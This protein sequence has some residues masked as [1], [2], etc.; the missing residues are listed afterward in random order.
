MSRRPLLIALLALVAVALLVPIVVVVLPGSGGDRSIVDRGAPESAGAAPAE[1]LRLDQ[2]AWVHAVPLFAGPAETYALQAGSLDVPVPVVDLEVPF[3]VD[4]N[5]NPGRSPAVSGVVDGH[6]VYV[7]DDGRRSSVR[8]V[9]IDANGADEEVATLD[10]I[11][12]SVAVAPDASHAYLALGDRVD[13][14]RDGG[15][16]RLSLDGLGR[17]ERILGPAPQAASQPSIIQAAVVSFHV[18]IS[19]SLDGRHLTRYSCNGA[20]GCVWQV[21]D[22]D[23]L[24]VIE[25]G[26]DRT[27]I[28]V[29]GGIAL[30]QHCRMECMIELVDLDTGLTEPIPAIEFEAT[31]TLL[32]GEPQVVFTQRHGD[33]TVLRLLDPGDGSVVDVL[34]PR[35]GSSITLLPPHAQVRLATPSGY[36]IAQISEEDHGVVVNVHTVAVR[37]DGG[38]VVELP[39]A[40][41]RDEFAGV[42]G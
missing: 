23:S 7:A 11:V 18:D 26:G 16:V 1:P 12:Y 34:A 25:L 38:A 6:V 20:A 33:V 9:P 28:G 41:I 21:I 29:A 24:E 5:S 14:E 10:D 22:L 8:R 36:V 37:L 2:V 40:P 35:R 27:I 17:V 39:A 32:G 15:I 4:P 30:T 31:L 19:I 13:P 42:E 3:G